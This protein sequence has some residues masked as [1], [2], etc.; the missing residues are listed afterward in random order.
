MKLGPVGRGPGR[1]P[2]LVFVTGEHGERILPD[3]LEG[4]ADLVVEVGSRTSRR[5]DRV[6]KFR[7][8]EAAG[9]REYWLIERE[10]MR[11]EFFGWNADGRY[12]ALPVEDG[13][14]RSRVLPGF[15][16]RIEWLWLVAG[17]HAGA[18]GAARAGP[19]PIV[20]PVGGAGSGA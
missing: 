5:R 15:W 17:S 6:D 4:P 14:F 16:L 12:E 19:T 7:E 1:E 11:A 3:R 8:Y 10:G 20:A 13:V 18:P 2:D 9:V